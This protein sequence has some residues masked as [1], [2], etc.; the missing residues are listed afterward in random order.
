MRDALRCN[1]LAEPNRGRRGRGS[2]QG[3][4]LP[5]ALREAVLRITPHHHI[6]PIDTMGNRNADDT[7]PLVKGTGDLLVLKALSWGPMHGF[8]I[9][10]WLQD[11][12][13]GA[14]AIDDTAMYQVLHRLEERGFIESEWGVS[15]NNR[16][17]R[18]YTLTSAGRAHLK[19][20]IESWLV[21]SRSVTKILTLA[22]RS[23]D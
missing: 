5:E 15:E 19:S 6:F 3:P 8:G 7:L 12:S 14:V 20:E 10:L 2:P 1:V 22:P 13:R 9:S 16:R 4:S 11:Q 18:F 17:A 23:S 21:R